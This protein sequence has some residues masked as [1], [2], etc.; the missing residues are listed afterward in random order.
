MKRRAQPISS[1]SRSSESDP[2]VGEDQKPKA[3]KRKS[4][5][6]DVEGDDSKSN[7]S[8]QD[9]S[10]SNGV[11][12]DGDSQEENAIHS[13]VA[14]SSNVDQNDSDHSSSSSSSVLEL[15][16]ASSD[17]NDDELASA[18]N[19]ATRSQSPS[20]TSGQRISTPTKF[21]VLFGRGFS[22]QMH[23]GNLRLHTVVKRHKAR[24]SNA[25]RLEKRAIIAEVVNLIKNGGP[26]NARFLERGAGSGKSHWIEQSDKRAM[27]K[28]G[29]ALRGKPRNTKKGSPSLSAAPAPVAELSGGSTAAPLAVSSNP[30][31][32]AVS[33]RQIAVDNY[34]YPISVAERDERRKLLDQISLLDTETLTAIVRQHSAGVIGGR[35]LAPATQPITLA[36]AT[37]FALGTQYVPIGLPR[38]S[39]VA[40]DLIAP[41][42]AFAASVAT[43]PDLLHQAQLSALTMGG[44][45]AELADPTLVAALLQQSHL[46]QRLLVGG[47]QQEEARRLLEAISQQTRQQNASEGPSSRAPSQNPPPS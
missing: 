18:N 8:E 32:A 2:T 19:D 21:D 42:S 33:S 20:A 29:H 11:T 16:G 31:V 28:V 27:E 22:Y 39:L 34:P 38:Q 40:S 5:D 26:Q 12:V 7:P 17:D 44:R 46:Q 1:S 24:Y 15:A 25:K 4:G 47:Q 35:P 9:S 37:P 30:A 6:V 3:V 13:G 45:Q 23:P 36:G 41:A 10:T 14:A 43:R